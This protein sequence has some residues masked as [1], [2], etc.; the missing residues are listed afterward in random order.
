M[1][2]IQNRFNS[3]FVESVSGDVTDKLRN[4]FKVPI[5]VG[6]ILRIG[7]LSQKQH[8]YAKELVQDRVLLILLLVTQEVKQG[9]V[10][11]KIHLRVPL[12]DK[13]MR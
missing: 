13:I 4:Y 5:F 3:I 7:R 2:N 12:K 11:L 1:F 10:H 9:E 8:K 6:F